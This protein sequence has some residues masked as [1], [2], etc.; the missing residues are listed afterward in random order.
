[1]KKRLVIFASGSGSNAENTCK[2]FRN[3]PETEVVAV[4]CNNKNA[5]VIRKMDAY[6]IPVVIFNRQQFADPKVFLETI[7]QYK[8]DAIALLGFLWLVPAFLIKAFPDRII[9]LHPALLPKYGGKGMYGHHVHEAVIAAGEKESGITM[10]LVN[11]HYDEGRTLAQ[12][13]CSVAPGDTPEVL[14]EKIHALEQAHVPAVI[15]SFLKG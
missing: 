8:P 9:N 10:H 13:R 11:E 1:M 15:D 4:F 5:G 6:Q 2:Y 14:A 7:Q 3:H 12:F